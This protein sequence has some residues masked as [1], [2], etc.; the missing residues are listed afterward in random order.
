MW[1]F[2]LPGVLGSVVFH[3]LV[4]KGGLCCELRGVVSYVVLCV[5][6]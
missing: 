1:C 6:L 5:V 4:V 2:E 3:I